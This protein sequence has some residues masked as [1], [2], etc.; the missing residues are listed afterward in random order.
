MPIM[1]V[2]CPDCSYDE[3]V[4]TVVP[5]EGERRIVVKL[6]CARGAEDGIVKC[7]NKWSLN[8]EIEIDEV[9]IEGALQ[10]REELIEEEDWG[11]VIRQAS[12]VQMMI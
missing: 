3:A 12:R 2:E 7:G 4:Y 8:Q 10:V 11:M 1:C 6:I 9:D 5:E